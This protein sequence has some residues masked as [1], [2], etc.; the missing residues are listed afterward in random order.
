MQERRVGWQVQ[1][2]RVPKL[3]YGRPCLAGVIHCWVCRSWCITGCA[4]ADTVNACVQEPYQ[5]SV[6]RRRASRSCS[7]QRT[8][9]SASG[10]LVCDC[11][12]AKV[13]YRHMK[14]L[15]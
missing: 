8:W 10:M 12:G 2:R 1:E 13:Y 7:P 15:L 11:R 6:K 3:F 14:V 9:T 5:T 4:G